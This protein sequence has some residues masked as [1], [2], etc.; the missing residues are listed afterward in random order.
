[1]V[2]LKFISFLGSI[3]NGL[4]VLIVRGTFINGDCVRFVHLAKNLGVV[5]DDI[6]SFGEQILKVVQSCYFTIRTLARIKCFLTPVQLHMAICAYVF[7][8]VD[9]CNCLYFGTNSHLLRKLQSVQNSAAR[10]LL[11]KSGENQIHIKKYMRDSHWLCVRDRISFKI[12]LI[13]FKS[14]CG[15]APVAL[16]EMCM[17]NSSERTVTLIQ[18]PFK[19]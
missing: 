14:L 6:L 13:M 7:S 17:F 8:R 16:Q 3:T 19:S 18:P 5:L 10:L 1:M 15:S 9:Y 4:I 12:C 2:T 11:K